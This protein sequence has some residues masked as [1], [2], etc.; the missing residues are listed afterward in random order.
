MNYTRE[1]INEINDYMLIGIAKSYLN[2]E[3]ILVGKDKDSYIHSKD[4]FKL[5]AFSNNEVFSTVGHESINNHTVYSTSNE[6][7]LVLDRSFNLDTKEF[8]ILG[9]SFNGE[10]MILPLENFN[11]VYTYENSFVPEDNLAISK[12]PIPQ[13]LNQ[14]SFLKKEQEGRKCLNIS[15]IQIQIYQ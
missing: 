15:N 11:D 10:Y 12:L 1:F 9:V 2:N 6:K 4:K 8:E 7:I 14:S 5:K 3:L 13:I